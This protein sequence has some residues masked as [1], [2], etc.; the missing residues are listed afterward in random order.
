LAVIIDKVVYHLVQ[1]ASIG[2][3]SQFAH[4]LGLARLQECWIKHGTF[5]LLDGDVRGEGV[6]LALGIKRLVRRELLMLGGFLA[7]RPLKN[8]ASVLVPAFH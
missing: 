1:V 5:F 3:L 2:N 6:F 7:K 8:M 4:R